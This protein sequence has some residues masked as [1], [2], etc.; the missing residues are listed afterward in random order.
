[1]RSFLVPPASWGDQLL[2]SPDEARHALKVLR[3]KPGAEI[4][5]VDGHG[6]EVLARIEQLS[7]EGGVAIPVSSVMT[8]PRQAQR[9]VGQGL[10]KGDKL[11]DILQHGTELGMDTLWPLKLERCVVKLD[12]EKAEGRRARWQRICSEAAKQSR[13]SEVPNVAPPAGLGSFLEAFRELSAP[14]LGVVLDEARAGVCSLPALLE[15][16]TG[17]EVLKRGSL[18]ALVGPEGG[19]SRAEVQAASDAGFVPVSLG[20]RILRTETAAL[21]LLAMLDYASARLEGQA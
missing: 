16:E 14:R 5:C 8:T 21:S 6:R 17:A 19:L 9:L 10:P 15:T 11:D 20:P 7:P 3:L 4:R 18:W 12:P 13:R 2:L 1:M